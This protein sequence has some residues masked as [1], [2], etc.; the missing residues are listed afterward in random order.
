MIELTVAQIAEIVGGAVA[1]I[2]PQDAAHRRVTGTVEF[3]SRAI[4]PGGLFLALPGARADGHD[5]A[6]S[7]VAAGAAVLLP[8]RPVGVPANV[9]PP[10]AAPNICAR[11]P[12]HAKHG[13]GAA[14][15]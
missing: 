14:G 4:G 6:A 10:V 1:D 15:R 2:S 12:Q 11:V 8:A 13:S 7:A 3:D 5:H 9:G